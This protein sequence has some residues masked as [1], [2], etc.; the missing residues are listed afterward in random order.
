MGRLR[1]LFFAG[2]FACVAPLPPALAQA[3][4]GDVQSGP[5]APSDSAFQSGWAVPQDSPLRSTHPSA[6]NNIGN[7]LASGAIPGESSPLCFQPGIGWRHAPQTALRSAGRL[8]ANTATGGGLGIQTGRPRIAGT[9]PSGTSRRIP[10]ECKS[11][12]ASGAATEALM[13]GKPTQAPNSASR[14][15]NMNLGAQDWL[16]ANSA[17][18]PASGLASS[19]LKMGL[20]PIPYSAMSF[21]QRAGS[22]DS[23]QAVQELRTHAYISTIELRRMMRNAPD[24]ETRLKLQELNDELKKKPVKPLENHEERGATEEKLEQD[25]KGLP[26][27][28][29]MSASELKMRRVGGSHE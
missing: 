11:S 21:S 14:T 24:L 19:R 29:S 15:T 10:D 26:D 13:A 28:S 5:V 6:A 27:S 7:T 12:L 22:G 23:L 2:L 18:N 25:L 4:S 20:S 9:P 3:S 17:L 8:T 1:G 16:R